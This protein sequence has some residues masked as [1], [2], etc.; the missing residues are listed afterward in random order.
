MFYDEQIVQE[1]GVEDFDQERQQEIIDAY[2]MEVGGILAGDLSEEK[3][4]EFEAIINGEQSVIDAWLQENA[5]DYQS[6]EAFQKLSEG[7]DEDPE[8]VPADKVY[9]SM[10]WVQKN[11]PDFAEKVEAVKQRFKSDIEQYK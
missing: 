2:R 4:E 5:P 1:L 7:Y 10:A 11:S 3:L 6:T 9:A 8:K